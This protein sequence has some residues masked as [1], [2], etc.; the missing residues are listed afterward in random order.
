MQHIERLP[1][2][3]SAQQHL[4]KQHILI[5]SAAGYGKSV[6]LNQ[7]L[8]YV[9]N[10]SYLRLTIEDNDVTWFKQRFNGA[11][12]EIL[13]IDDVHHLETDGPSSE[14]LREQFNQVSPKLVVAGRYAPFPDMGSLKQVAHWDE[15]KLAF[16]AETVTHLLEDTDEQL[17]NMLDGWPMG[18][19]LLRQLPSEHRRLAVAHD[20]TFNYL[21]KAVFDQLSA[22]LQ[23][24]LCLTAVPQTFTVD[25]IAHLSKKTPSRTQDQINHI[26]QKNLFIFQSEN[27]YRYHDLFREFLNNLIPLKYQTLLNQVAAWHYRHEDFIASVE[28]YLLA[29]NQN[30]A[31]TVMD[32][33]KATLLNQQSR[34]LTYRRWIRT[35]DKKLLPKYPELVFE[36]TNQIQYDFRY[37]EEVEALLTFMSQSELLTEDQHAHLTLQRGNFYVIKHNY[38]RAIELITPLVE[39]NKLSSRWLV[40]AC[41]IVAVCY[42][43]QLKLRRG[44]Y[45]FELALKFAKETEPISR[46]SNVMNNM[47]VQAL[48]HLGEYERAHQ[49]IVYTITHEEDSYW[50]LRYLISGCSVALTY[51]DFELMQQY[52]QRT[53]HLYGSV[54]NIF[55]HDQ[56]FLIYFRA[57]LQ[58]FHLKG[59]AR[60]PLNTN[61]E[62]G[63][64]EEI[65]RVFFELIIA[66]MCNDHSKIA[67]FKEEGRTVVN[68]FEDHAY[69]RA[70][71]ALEADISDGLAYFYGEQPTFEVSD[72]T[73]NLIKARCK[74]DIVRINALLTLVA[75]RQK[76]PKWRKRAQAVL[77]ATQKSTY[78]QL[79][80]HRDR[81]L[82]VAF[83]TLMLSEQVEP[84]RAKK[85]LL[86]IGRSAPLFTLLANDIAQVRQQAAELLVDI[87]DERAMPPLNQAIG[88]E[89]DKPTK[90]ILKE[91]LT[92]LETLPPPA[93]DIRL[94]GG[95]TVTRDGIPIT[96]FHR[97]IVV[98]LLQY[99]A[100]RR[101]RPVGR[102]RIL[103][104]I[105]PDSPPDKAWVTFKTV[106]SRLRSTLEPHMRSKGPNRYFALMGD[107]Y[108]FDPNG[109]VTVDVAHFQDQVSQALAS[110]APLNASLVTLIEAY[111]P[112]LPE[113]MYED[114]LLE[115]REQ[116]SDLYIQAALR[117]GQQKLAHG[118]LQEAQQWAQT[119]IQAAPWMETAYQLLMRAYARQNQR[120]SALRTYENAQRTLQKELAVE[121]S[122]L[123]RWLCARLKGGESI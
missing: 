107:S 31:L 99:F 63:E 42:T 56:Q 98:R 78:H 51:G 2:I 4:E 5:E 50:Q 62:N 76:H 117:M 46:I 12:G 79:L 66:R 77:R 72:L 120:G 119:V 75:Y 123:T 69:D 41:Q 95:F 108:L 57:I 10:S 87:G 103:E 21:A 48:A 53:E 111:S 11:D 80:T 65:Y 70:L 15:S 35:V 6:F 83:W 73:K 36:Y 7:L 43:E 110:A 112:I 13:L 91:A 49:N 24:F 94:M 60:S 45:Y 97:P 86:K 96:D 101:G 39:Q 81:A 18:V 52:L 82:G 122:D 71:I 58:A 118:E 19:G 55:A 89:K 16:S 27:V 59:E 23:E 14:W 34:N 104:D 113:A 92:T 93:V 84:K 85:A 47:A 26:Q 3:Q 44:K 17:L 100:T 74:G 40:T 33:A 32:N 68:R 114:W 102:D 106:Y 1:L 22:D 29:K 37:R 61:R 88:R 116:T 90:T 25:L 64:S 105:W 54:E 67:Q 28:H 38:S 20:E 9:P 109:Y 121:P 30:K 8:G 115:L